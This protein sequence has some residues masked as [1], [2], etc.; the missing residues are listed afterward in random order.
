MRVLTVG[1]AMVDTI[2]IID[3][4]RIERMTMFN[5][6]S[7]F[8]L[9]EEGGKTFIHPFDDTDVIAGQGTM[10][11]EILEDVPDVET[12]IVPIG[13]G[14]LISGISTLVK[15]KRPKESTRIAPSVAKE[16]L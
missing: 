15:K 7:S 8:L 1:G 4:D 16:E 12:I 9:L 6:E 3:S 11:L 10:G 5:A 2:A 13:G 14:G